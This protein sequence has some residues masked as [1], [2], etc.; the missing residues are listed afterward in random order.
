M[1]ASK[2]L[3]PIDRMKRAC[4]ADS[5][6]EQFRNA[7][8]ENA[9]LFLASLIDVYGSDKS[10]QK[11]QP[12]AVIMEALK[13]AT[14]RLPINKQLGFAYIVPY[15]DVPQFQ[16]GYKGYIQ[17][18]MRTGQYRHINADLVYE[19]ELRGQDKLTGEIDLSGEPTGSNVIGY[20]AHIETVNGFRKTLYWSKERVLAHAK[21]YSK[22]FSQPS[23][24]W[25]SNFDEMAL[26]TMIRNLLS[27]Y[28][29]MSVDMVQ[30][31]TADRDESTYEAQVLGEVE[32]DANTGPVVDVEPDNGFPVAAGPAASEAPQAGPDF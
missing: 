3:T 32:E 31:F 17:L 12:G 14:L 24:A 27:K 11:C 30:A 8:A 23:S 4:A 2:A 1:E 28:G 29:V 25:Q 9:P 22:S 16:L 21:R 10:L 19:G 7:M 13:A 18:A 5:V 20:F 26:K 6:Q 15:K